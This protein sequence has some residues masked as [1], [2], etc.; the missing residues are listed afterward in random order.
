MLLLVL[1]MIQRCFVPLK[2][3]NMVCNNVPIKLVL[4]M[5]D[6]KHRLTH[7][8][9]ILQYNLEISFPDVWCFGMF[10]SL[11]ILKNMYLST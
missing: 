2:D 5:G 11:E 9:E 1:S 8:S 7:L 10:L 3:E 4:K 6:S